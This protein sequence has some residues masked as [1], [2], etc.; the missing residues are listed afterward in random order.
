VTSCGSAAT[1]YTLGLS[2]RLTWI[3]G[4]ARGCISL[5]RCDDT[6][7][8]GAGSP[9]RL[10]AKRNPGASRLAPRQRNQPLD[11]DRLSHSNFRVTSNGDSDD[12][13][14]EAVQGHQ[15][16]QPEANRSADRSSVGPYQRRSSAPARGCIQKWC[17]WYQ[18]AISWWCVLSSWLWPNGVVGRITQWSRTTAAIANGGLKH[19][20]ALCK[21]VRRR[22]TVGLAN[23]LWVN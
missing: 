16:G 3:A 18:S 2:R 8:L 11:L 14:A 17:R 21:T 5:R 1:C 22:H 13:T 23:R 10:G 9:G 7:Q 6:G 15:L 4:C 20:T 19:T 12:L